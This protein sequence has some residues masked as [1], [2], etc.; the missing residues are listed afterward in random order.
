MLVSFFF[1]MICITVKVIIPNILNMLDE[2]NTILSPV[3]GGLM[4]PP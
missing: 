1:L 2:C 4:S 3:C